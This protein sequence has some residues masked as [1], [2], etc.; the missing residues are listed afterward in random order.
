MIVAI[1]NIKYLFFEVLISGEKF[2]A[3]NEPKKIE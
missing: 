2:I 1:K 3:T